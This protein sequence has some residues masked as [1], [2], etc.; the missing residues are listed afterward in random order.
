MPFCAL[1]QTDE[2]RTWRRSKRKMSK[3]R[4]FRNSIGHFP[5][6][7]S[8]AALVVCAT[9]ASCISFFLFS[10]NSICVKFLLEISKETKKNRRWERRRCVEIGQ[11]VQF[12][13]LFIWR[14]WCQWNQSANRENHLRIL[15]IILIELAN[16]ANRLQKHVFQLN[17]FNWI[18]F[19]ESKSEQE[20]RPFAAHSIALTKWFFFLLFSDK[21][22]DA[23]STDAWLIFSSRNGNKLMKSE[24]EFCPSSISLFQLWIVESA[25]EVVRWNAEK[26]QKKTEKKAMRM[27]FEE[28]NKNE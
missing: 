11:K 23:H 7:L 2:L 12:S 14:C 22:M 21:Q 15:I 24:S 9:V 3:S 25:D 17:S 27:H 26:E 1:E 10:E 4:W 16:E 28:N 6:S 18:D 5:L 20:K 13:R 19:I 8:F